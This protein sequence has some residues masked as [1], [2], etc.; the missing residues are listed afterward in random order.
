MNT[1]SNTNNEN[2]CIFLL[3]IIGYA[4]ILAVIAALLSMLFPIYM[5]W[6]ILGVVLLFFAGMGFT[7]GFEWGGPKM[8]SDVRAQVKNFG[9]SMLILIISLSVFECRFHISI[10]SII[11]CLVSVSS[12]AIATML[13]FLIGRSIAKQRNYGNEEH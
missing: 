10:I 13:G 8:T 12:I 9:L 11:R 3:W 1:Q 6:F 5:P 4:A 2:S 7:A